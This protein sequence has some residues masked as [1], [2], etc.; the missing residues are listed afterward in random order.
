MERLLFSNYACCWRAE[1]PQHPPAWQ[2]VQGKAQKLQH[3]LAEWGTVQQA[4]GKRSV[5]AK[6]PIDKEKEKDRKEDKKQP[7]KVYSMHTFI[8]KI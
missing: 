1:L 7:D 4:V 6:I 8:N 3:K 5:I 2:A